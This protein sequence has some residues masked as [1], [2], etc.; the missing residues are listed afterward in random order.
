MAEIFLFKPE[1]RLAAEGNLKNFIER[2]KSDLTVFGKDLYWGAPVWPN[3]A[4]FSKLGVRTRKPDN[5]ELLDPQYSDFARAYFRYQQ[6]HNPTGSRNE[7]KALRAVEAA[8]LQLTGKAD[9]NHLS[10]RVLDQAAILARDY[11]SGGAAYQ[12]GRE[13]KRLA[14]FVSENELIESSLH[15]WRNPICRPEEKNKTGQHAR[16]EREKRLPDETASNALAE[17]FSNEP[18][19]PRDS[20]TVS[21]YALL[22][23]APSRISEVLSLPVDCGHS[24]K[25]QGK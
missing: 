1:K 19:S 2:C 12:C 24:E 9:I 4:V 18:E 20:F 13:V 17:I 7:L 3:V 10:I 8:L 6:G 23:C 5:S 22:M 25:D 14:V 16:I 15:D 11:Y 21:V